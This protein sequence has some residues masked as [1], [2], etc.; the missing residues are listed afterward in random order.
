MPSLITWILAVYGIAFLLSD[1]K[2]LSEWIPVRPLLQRVGFIREL[3]RC[4]FCMGVWISA[5]GWVWW[6][7]PNIF[8]KDSLLYIFAGATGTYV[9]NCVL[10]YLE[11]R[12]MAEGARALS[13]TE[14]SD[15]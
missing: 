11:A 7:W 6:S 4:Y 15:G 3:L 1:A 14:D 5:G 2:I 8:M 9:L 10:E 12:T 13:L